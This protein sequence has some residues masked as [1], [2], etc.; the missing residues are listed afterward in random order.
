MKREGVKAG[1][2]DVFLPVARG[3]Y[4]GLYIELKVGENK[5]SSDQKWWIAQTTKQGYCSTVCYGWVEA[6]GVIEKYLE[7]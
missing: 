7:G 4:H 3:K 1:V 2:S 6:K 5:T